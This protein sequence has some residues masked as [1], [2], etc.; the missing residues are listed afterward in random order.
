[1][2]RSVSAANLAPYNS[3]RGSRGATPTNSRTGSRRREVRPP[4]PVDVAEQYAAAYG[5]L[6]TLVGPDAPPLEP[7]SF[8]PPPRTPDGNDATARPLS[9]TSQGRQYTGIPQRLPTPPRPPA[10]LTSA[11]FHASQS[12]GSLPNSP[13]LAGLKP[14]PPPPG[15]LLG[16][17]GGHPLSRGDLAPPH[18]GSV[19]L[20]GGAHGSGAKG[21]GAHGGNAD[22]GVVAEFFALTPEQ[23]RQQL[24]KAWLAHG[25]PPL[26]DDLPKRVASVRPLYSPP[27]SSWTA[28]RVAAEKKQAAQQQAAAEQEP[29]PAGATGAFPGPSFFREETGAML[30]TSFSPTLPPA[31]G[32]RVAG[33]HAATYGPYQGGSP[34]RGIGARGRDQTAGL[35]PR[36]HTAPERATRGQ[37]QQDKPMHPR[38]AAAAHAKPKLLQF[39]AGGGDSSL[40]ALEA[41]HQLRDGDAAPRSRLA[42][43]KSSGSPLGV[44]LEVATHRHGQQHHVTGD[45]PALRST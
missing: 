17:P 45:D 9:S 25:T 12:A 16:S 4:L 7:I 36:Q 15:S 13:K 40:A 37:P 44:E 26:A 24:R 34:A 41:L 3:P 18:R 19:A 42:A 39:P 43:R 6:S 32:A 22:G 28:R 2:A 33:G 35:P 8:P 30:S 31:K 20:L 27:S 23:Q 10:S 1:M 21:G 11:K 5:V 29:P 14:W 38:P